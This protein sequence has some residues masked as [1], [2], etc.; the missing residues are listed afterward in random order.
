MGVV[1]VV[2]AVEVVR[3]GG[4][5]VVEVVDARD[6]LEAG[7]CG[8]RREAIAGSFDRDQGSVVRDQKKTAE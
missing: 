6:G 8:I 1:G 4:D 2:V 7:Q 5:L 3:R